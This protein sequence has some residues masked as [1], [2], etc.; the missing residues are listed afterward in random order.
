MK[1][2]FDEER[3]VQRV[4]IIQLASVHGISNQSR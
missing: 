1:S 2:F 3:I 4:S